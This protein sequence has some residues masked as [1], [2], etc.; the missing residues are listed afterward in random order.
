MNRR[1]ILELTVGIILLVAVFLFGQRGMAV[2]ALLAIH[3]FIEKKKKLDERELQ[4][5]YKVGNFTAGATLLVC[6]AVYYFPDF[7]VNG[8]TLG[9]NWLSHVYS[10]FVI[11]H[12]GSGLFLFNKK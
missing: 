6:V 4:L 3:P 2:L 12:G 8:Q 9:E 1:F 5:F 11:F 7:A 10:A